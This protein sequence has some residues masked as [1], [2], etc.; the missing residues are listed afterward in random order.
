MITLLTAII[1]FIIGRLSYTPRR[2]EKE[3][4]DD[5]I[6][7]VKK[8]KIKPGP[9]KFKTPEEFEAERNGDK[10]LEEQ[11]VKSGILERINE[12]K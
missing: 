4:I 11:W 2:K 3:T 10:E 12:A 7:K 9:I 1:F 6:E 8:N 5:I